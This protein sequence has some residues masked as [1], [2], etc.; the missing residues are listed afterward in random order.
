MNISTLGAYIVV[1]HAEGLNIYNIYARYVASSRRSKVVCGTLTKEKTMENKREKKKKGENNFFDCSGIELVTAPLAI[2]FNFR[3]RVFSH[4]NQ[5]AHP[6]FPFPFLPFIMPSLLFCYLLFL[7]ILFSKF[8]LLT[9]FSLFFLQRLCLF[10][11][12]TS[13]FFWIFLL[14]FLL[15]SLLLYPTPFP[16]FHL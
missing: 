4:Q 8:T 16:F 7:F 14:P 2:A 1:F 10:L 6:L 5:P 13:L 15:S 11:F 3:L 9:T 12:S